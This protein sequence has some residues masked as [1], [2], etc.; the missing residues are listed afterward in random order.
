MF[1][2]SASESYFEMSH[3]DAEQ[4]LMLYR[5][6]CKQ[7]ERVMDYLSI[8]RKL[9]PILNIPIPQLRHVSPRH[10]WSKKI[11]HSNSLGTRFFSWGTGGVS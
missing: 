9:E 7:T 4:A 3:V 11:L 5:H 10:F 6:F 8:A 2:N 1:L